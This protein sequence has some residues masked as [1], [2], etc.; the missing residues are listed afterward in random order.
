M[1][2]LNLSLMAILIT[3]AV[4]PQLVFSME[5]PT[6]QTQST[7]NIVYKSEKVRTVNGKPQ[8]RIENRRTLADGTTTIDYQWLPINRIEEPCA[9][10][11]V[12]Y[13]RFQDEQFNR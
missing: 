10:P 13:T 8:I 9:S 4:M 7:D 1:K 3:V 2:R 5:L 11:I 12:R 6:G